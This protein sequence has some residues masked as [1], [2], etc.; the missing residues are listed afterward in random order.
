MGDT[1]TDTGDVVME[2]EEASTPSTEPT[3]P[4]PTSVSVSV[5]GN[6]S[7][8]EL[9][10]SEPAA[11]GM[12]STLSL[13]SID[14]TI[15]L[16][17]AFESLARSSHSP[18]PSPP[19]TAPS[20]LS[21]T[22]SGA[23]PSPTRNGRSTG[24]TATTT[25]TKPKNNTPNRRR[26][27]AATTS[28]TTAT[29]TSTTAANGVTTNDSG[30]TG[31]PTSTSTAAARRRSR[32]DLDK[33]PKKKKRRK[34][35]I[36]SKKA[37]A[38]DK[39]KELAAAEEEKKTLEDEPIL[40]SQNDRSL[41]I[42]VSTDRLT[43]TGDKGYRSI[44]A[45]HGIMEGEFYYE[46]KWIL[47][48]TR[49]PMSGPGLTNLQNRILEDESHI[50][51]GWGA[52]KADIQ[53]PV[54]VDRYGFAYG[55]V[56]GRKIHESRP[57]DYT[58]ISF[59]PGDIIG[60]YIYLPSVAEA[61]SLAAAEAAS[62]QPKSHDDPLLP[63]I[64]KSTIAYVPIGLP[65]K[66]SKVVFYKNGVS[67]GAAFTDIPRETYYPMISLYMAA[68][69]Q[70]TFKPPF[71]YL[72]PD[73]PTKLFQPAAPA[74]P[75]P[76]VAAPQPAVLTVADSMVSAVDI[77]SFTPLAPTLPPAP[78]VPPS[79][80]SSSSFES[81]LSLTTTAIITSTTVFTDGTPASTVVVEQPT[82]P[83]LP[84]PYTIIDF[85]H[86]PKLKKR[87]VAAAPRM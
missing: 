86:P 7:T 11:V 71:A 34:K 72:P 87:L 54:G 82:A 85:V 5:S 30:V 29:G 78:S 6:A 38:A 73:L 9:T 64:V 65:L 49:T 79:A 15:P 81:S 10:S 26:T 23:G 83:P 48:T 2:H 37:A 3:P 20:S 32:N 63:S 25:V 1:N 36:E 84:P 75:Q 76:L 44:R 67:L 12:A 43:A 40:L 27:G 41:K 50:R 35:T 8:T 28:G 4:P 45:T 74:P 39:A 59:A 57:R 66:G 61:T 13:I 18:S 47:P 56:G 60:C 58:G 22:G 70:M 14:D 52:S 80:L 51:L 24:R 31:A 19:P 69:V 55:D 77:A 16:A 62:A 33:E 17:A 42:K 68:C 21:S 53:A 46:M